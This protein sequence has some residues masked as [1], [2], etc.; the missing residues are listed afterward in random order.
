[1]TK[2]RSLLLAGVSMAIFV[3]APGCGDSSPTLQEGSPQDASR[4]WPAGSLDRQMKGRTPTEMPVAGQVF[5][6]RLR[7]VAIRLDEHG[8]VSGRRLDDPA[9]LDV[10]ESEL[11][12]ISVDLED[13]DAEFRHRRVVVERFDLGA[14]G[15][16]RLRLHALRGPNIAR[17]LR[18]L[19][20]HPA[21]PDLTMEGL[22]ILDGDGVRTAM[23]DVSH[24]RFFGHLP[25]FDEIKAAAESGAAAA[26]AVSR[27]GETIEDIQVPKLVDVAGRAGRAL[28]IPLIY[29][30]EANR[31]HLQIAQN[32]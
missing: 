27:S 20:P 21:S 31:Q 11:R 7:E 10:V 29:A 14:W 12:R 2:I 28:P 1:M 9:S 18:N 17:I 8:L 13:L 4:P 30:P 16:H 26:I 23:V 22:R 3:A 6:R 24:I 32:Q 15:G 5:W 19:V 25:D